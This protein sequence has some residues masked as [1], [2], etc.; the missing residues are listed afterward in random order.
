MNK[1]VDLLDATARI[2][3]G[4]CC[5]LLAH[6]ATGSDITRSSRQSDWAVLGLS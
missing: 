2:A 3:G 5:D 1:N 6:L 4:V